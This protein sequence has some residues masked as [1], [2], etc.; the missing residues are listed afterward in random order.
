MASQRVT[1]SREADDIMAEWLKKHLG[2][3]KAKRTPA[4]LSGV[5]I[6]NTPGLAPEGKATGKFNIMASLRQAV[7]NAKNGDLPF[8]YYRPNGFGEA[9]IAEWPII[10]RNDDF[11]ELLKKAGYARE[12]ED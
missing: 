11:T 1:R 10:L 4:S 5:D 2:F 9:K 7:K 8:V 3:S 12:D 6:Q